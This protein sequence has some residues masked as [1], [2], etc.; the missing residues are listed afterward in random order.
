MKSRRWIYNAGEVDI[1]S[2]LW[3]MNTILVL[4]G[5]FASSRLIMA[6]ASA[7][8]RDCGSVAW[9]ELMFSSFRL[10]QN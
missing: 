1:S 4:S 9:S 10:E 2:Y 8:R 6:P 5:I 7:N 3:A